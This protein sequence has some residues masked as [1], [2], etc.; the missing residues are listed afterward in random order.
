[1]N[2]K[3]QL[4]NS[5]LT[6]IEKA[7]VALV[8]D[9]HLHAQD[10]SF[11]ERYPTGHCNAE[12]SVEEQL[13]CLTE[14]QLQRVANLQ[15]T[16]G[17]K[18]RDMWREWGKAGVFE[19]APA[20]L[21]TKSGVPMLR[22]RHDSYLHWMRGYC[23]Q[24]S[25][26]AHCNGSNG[27]SGST[28]ARDAS[29]IEL[30][31]YS[32]LWDN[33][34]DGDVQEAWETQWSVFRK[35]M[36]LAHPFMA[37]AGKNSFHKMLECYAETFEE[38][39][40]QTDDSVMKLRLD[41]SLTLTAMREKCAS[42]EYDSTT[43]LD[44]AVMGALDKQVGLL[45]FGST[46]VQFSWNSREGF[47]QMTI[48]FPEWDKDAYVQE[49]YDCVDLNARHPWQ[50]AEQEYLY[51]IWCNLSATLLTLAG[52]DSRYFRPANGNVFL[53]TDVCFYPEKQR[54]HN[55]EEMWSALYEAR[56]TL[57]SFQDMANEITVN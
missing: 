46:A 15:I 3:Q 27:G 8:D 48:R 52:M 24:N 40:N 21:D 29:I 7:K 25:Y 9:Q 10:T 55:A 33:E 20:I 31:V 45:R 37:C 1:M 42:T 32:A 41:K 39:V 47:R 43:L 54:V 4:V 13:S 14:E 38:F 17:I 12:Y 26:D 2:N 16:P 11:W 57:R 44:L 28:L 18:F 36:I 50:P 56:S 35:A 6:K 30:P 22:I 51:S 34:D 19:C 5:I 49:L 53:A 23:F